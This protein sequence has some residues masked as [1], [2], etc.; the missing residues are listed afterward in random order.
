MAALLQDTLANPE[1]LPFG[2]ALPDPELLPRKQL[3]REVRQ[4]AGKYAGGELI[5]YCHPSGLKSLRTEIEKRMMGSFDSDL[6]EEVIITGGCLAAIDLCLRAVAGSGDIIL[7]ESPTF[8][9]YLQLIEDLHMRALEIPV[10]ADT[11]IDVDLLLQALDSH[12]VRAALLNANFHNP[13]GY[14]N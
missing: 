9:C 2:T 12:D 8:L 6:G 5:G 4:A 1:M 3:A 11:G 10:D 7:V 13:L 14:V